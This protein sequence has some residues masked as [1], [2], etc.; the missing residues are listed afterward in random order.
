MSSSNGGVKETAKLFLVFAK[1]AE[2]LSCSAKGTT[3][4]QESVIEGINE[5]AFQDFQGLL[6]EL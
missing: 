4:Q 1:V 6:Q 3:G 5:V 2:M